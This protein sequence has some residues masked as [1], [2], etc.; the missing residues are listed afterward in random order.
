MEEDIPKTVYRCMECGKDFKRW[1][2]QIQNPKVMTCSTACAGKV[3]GRAHRGKNNPAYKHGRY[4][5]PTEEYQRGEYPGQNYTLE[6][7]IP[8]QDVIDVVSFSTSFREVAM[9]LGVGTYAA[10]RRVRKMRI[11]TSHFS[12]TRSRSALPNEIFTKGWKKKRA[13]SRRLLRVLAEEG[14]IDTLSCAEC[15]L[16]GEWNGGPL[17]MHLHHA[18]GDS[19]DDRIENL[20]VLCPNCHT[21]TDTYTGRNAAHAKD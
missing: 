3:L 7:D 15:G 14:L 12:W 17:R 5:K 21:Q 18:N 8:D 19:T 11:D 16:A 6:R 13:S 9:K 2:S 20:S 10:T 4:A 1:P